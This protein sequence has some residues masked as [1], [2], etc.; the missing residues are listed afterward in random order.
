MAAPQDTL[1][2]LGLT[3]YHILEAPC[4]AALT[5]PGKHR[6]LDLLGT[7]PG[8]Q[9]VITSP[10]GL[11]CMQRETDARHWGGSFLTS[12]LFKKWPSCL[13]VDMPTGPWREER[14]LNATSVG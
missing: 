8:A 6:V 3:A 1:N 2:T 9:R 5:R 12:I 7:G 14:E 4:N 13:A 10:C 11:S